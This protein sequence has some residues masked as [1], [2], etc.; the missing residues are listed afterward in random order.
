MSPNR[1][2]ALLT[3]I[4]F[5]PLAGTIAALLAE[6]FP[7]VDIPQDKIQQVFIAGALI[8]FGKA[9]QWT[10]GWQKYEAREA[11][12]ETEAQQLDT[13][14]ADLDARAS[15]WAY[16]DAPVPDYADGPAYD[17]E[18]DGEPSYGGNGAGG[19]GAAVVDEV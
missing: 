17:P 9:A 8:A 3:P 6:H 11:Q 1:V 14:A 15:E 7:G 16:D 13:R 12:R 2:V 10:H 4:A 18:I 5:A 19:S